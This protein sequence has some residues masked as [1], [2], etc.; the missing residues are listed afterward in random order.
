MSFLSEDSRESKKL[1]RL[2][3]LY[4]LPLIFNEKA[5]VIESNSD[6]DLYQTLILPTHALNSSIINISQQFSNNNN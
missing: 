1:Q 2:S 6:L 4:G 3:K 5:V